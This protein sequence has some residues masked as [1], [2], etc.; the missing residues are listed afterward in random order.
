MYHTHT[1]THTH[2]QT[3]THTHTNTHTQFRC[4]HTSYAEL[5]HTLLS[6]MHYLMAER[7]APISPIWVPYICVL[8][9]LI[10]TF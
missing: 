5:K 1:H 8:I 2:T 3:H 9:S 7:C 10:N 4:P 6:W